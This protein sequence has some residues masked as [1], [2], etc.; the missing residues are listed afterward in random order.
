VEHVVQDRL[1]LRLTDVAT[2]ACHGVP[3]CE[4]ATITVASPAGVLMLG[5]TSVD[6][7][8]LASVQMG[9]GD[10]P[11]L[12]AQQEGVLVRVDDYRRDRRWPAVARAAL[13]AGFRSSLSVPLQD[14]ERVLGSLDLHARAAR[15]FGRRSEQVGEVLARQAVGA[16][17]DVESAR[18]TGVAHLAQHRIAQTLQRDLLP[19]VP[20]LPGITSAA[21][22]VAVER[23]AVV[24]GDWYDV[25]LRPDQA[26]GVAIGDVVGHDV[27]AAATMGQLRSVLRSYAYEAS[28]PGD[29]LDRLDRLV[30]GFDLGL[31]TV[32]FG[33]LLLDRG[34]ACLTFSNA[35]HL[36]P[37]VRQP[38]GVVR[39]LDQGSSW[40][41]GVPPSRQGSRTDAAVWLPEGSTLVLYTDGLVE[42][43]RRHLDEGLSRL[44]AALSGT[45]VDSGP[46]ALCDRV[47]EAMADGWTDDLA[48]LAVRVD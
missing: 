20:V 15:A 2:M 13:Q 32:V 17:S 11:C 45:L 39:T 9:A 35:G 30:Q 41:I 16:I 5:T 34:G 38:D 25:F 29:V 28:S 3:G 7:S 19:V 44:V 48:L 36:P 18:R 33:T 14:G 21:R 4:A 46:E 27:A 31:A 43:R 40:L 23:S 26:I 1:R 8:Y 22:Y 6:A 12:H 10:G 24:G 42:R 47:L 37:I